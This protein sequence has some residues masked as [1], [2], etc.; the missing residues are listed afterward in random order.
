[1]DSKLQRI[2]QSQEE[3]KRWSKMKDVAAAKKKRDASVSYKVLC[4]ATAVCVL[5]FASSLSKVAGRKSVWPIVHSITM[6]KV[7]AFK[8]LH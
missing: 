2:A 8:S 5:I 7:S 4:G 1:M 6:M 3:Y